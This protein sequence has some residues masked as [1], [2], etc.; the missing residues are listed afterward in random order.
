MLEHGQLLGFRGLLKRRSQLIHM[1]PSLHTRCSSSE[2]VL[3]FGG[4]GNDGLDYLNCSANALL[5][6]EPGVTRRR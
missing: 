4:S 1:C 6:R 2:G 3:R 5:A